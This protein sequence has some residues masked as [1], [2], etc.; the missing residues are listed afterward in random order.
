MRFDRPALTRTRWLRSMAAMVLAVSMALA[1]G[2]RGA[3]A[4]DAPKPPAL[5]SAEA[6]SATVI[7]IKYASLDDGVDM[8]IVSAYPDGDGANYFKAWNNS[9]AL[10]P[11][12]GELVFDE[13][14]PD[15]RYCISIQAGRDGEQSNPTARRCVTTPAQIAVTAPNLIIT[16]I[17]GKEELDW[18]QTNQ[19]SPVY[20]L[21]LQNDGADANGT[22]VVEIQTS[23]VVTLTDQL[24]ILQQGWE[25]LGFSC[26]RTPA[27][28]G[29]N[30]SMLC[31]GGT[32]KQ[33]E[34]RDPAVLTRVTGRGFGYVHVAINVNRAPADSDPSDNRLTLGVQAT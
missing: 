13:A 8:V 32:L 4:A 34:A 28:G 1:G 31:T 16:E 12:S 21:M 19:R 25:S 2:W 29:A 10:M 23:G 14:L 26:E 6:Q 22:V 15:T 9:G 30:A 3:T 7:K 27:S 5:V 11:K 18:D 33:G 20:I 24:P 17:R